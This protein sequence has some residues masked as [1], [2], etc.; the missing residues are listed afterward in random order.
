MSR[1]RTGASVHRSILLITVVA[2]AAAILFTSQPEA[3]AGTLRVNWDT[4]DADDLAGYRLRYGT[5]GVSFDAQLLVPNPA[6]VSREVTGLAVGT[7]YYF[8]VQA[9]DDSSNFSPYSDVA[10]ATVVPWD[11]QAPVP[12]LDPALVSLSS[13]LFEISWDVSAFADVAAAGVE[14]SKVNSGFANPN[15]ADWDPDNCC[16]SSTTLLDGVSGTEVMDAAGF[17]GPGVYQIRVVGLDAFGTIASHFSDSATFE[18]LAGA[19]PVDPD[20]STVTAAPAEIPADGQS[21]SLIT[22]TPRDS[23]SALAGPG[24][25]V[26]LETTAG[27]LLGAVQDNGDGT[28][29]QQLQSSMD[30]TTAQVGAVAGGVALTQQAAVAFAGIPA[31]ILT[32]PGPGDSNPPQV[33]VFD[34]ATGQ[35]VG[36]DFMAYGV[37][38][39]GVNVGAGDVTG[40]GNIEILTG[41]GPGSVFGPQIRVFDDQGTPFNTFMAYGTMRWGAK[42]S[43]AD[44]DGDHVDEILTSPGPGEVFGPH[45]RAFDFDGSSEFVPIDGVSYFSYGTLK[46]GANVAGGDIDGDGI[47]EIITGAGPGTVFGPHV[48]AWNYDGA[49][50]EP[51]SA[52]SFM[53]YGTMQFGVNVACG[54]IDG[55]GMDEIIT[56]PGPG[57]VFGP[58]VRA[59]DFDGDQLVPIAGVSFN[60]FDIDLKYGVNVACGD[61]DGDGIDEILTGP[62]P[63]PEGDEAYAARVLAWNYDGGTLEQI[64][65]LDILAYGET[66]LRMT[67]EGEKEEKAKAESTVV[68]LLQ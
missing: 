47:D 55:D 37:A 13:P 6:A 14:V 16:F 29:T 51:I 38:R 58:H 57:V 53:A 43:A 34:P 56:G 1:Y 40:D 46:F 28:Y 31:M 52:V 22:V 27:T 59:F 49:R 54:D 41:P 19:P 62:G 11:G 26:T 48:R 18:V 61:L 50:L 23:S 17:E 33:R 8:V 36:I 2:L 9:Y 7:T 64:P 5:D 65:G 4:V 32:G 25:A 24:L 3:R 10:S 67:G 60:A 12:G 35:P 39:W 20:T 66:I 21:V 44:I 30:V 15:G 68:S 45:I 63:G 42:V